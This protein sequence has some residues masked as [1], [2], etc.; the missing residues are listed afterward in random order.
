MHGEPASDLMHAYL[1]AA[2]AIRG[3]DTPYAPEG[4]F[5]I[6]SETAYVN[7]PVLAELLVPLTLVSV[8]KAEALATVAAFVLLFG[9][10]WLTGVRDPICY[11]AVCLWLPTFNAIQNANASLLVAFLVAVAWRLRDGSGGAVATAVAIAVKPFVWPLLVW[12]AACGRTRSALLAA[13]SAIALML[14][15]WIPLGFAG[16]SRFVRINQEVANI[17]DVKGYSVVALGDAVG[18]SNAAATAA[19]VAIG[20]VLLLACFRAGQR[21]NECQSLALALAAAL[22]MTP[23]VWQHYLIVLVVPL[24]VA[25]P[26]A[27]WPW[28]V[29]IVAWAAPTA[30]N[31]AP[32]QTLIVPAVAALLVFA[33][34]VPGTP[35]LRRRTVPA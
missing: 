22:V 12:Q 27:S 16:L 31:G 10:L 5:S 13:G 20:L 15:S 26:R 23:V 3:G 25:R 17:E 11:G 4:D 8:G 2:H 34:I 35:S 24:A 32:W 6:V 30:G 7:P 28:F 18:V 21:G 19:A 9:M 1:P 29:P 14:I 33:S